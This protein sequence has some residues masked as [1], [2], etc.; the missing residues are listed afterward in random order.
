MRPFDYVSPKSQAQAL[1]LLG[2]SW[3]NTE[4]LAGGTDLLALMRSVPPAR[5][6]AP[7]LALARS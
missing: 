2:T 6:S 3:G 7:P 1:S 5:G 4:V